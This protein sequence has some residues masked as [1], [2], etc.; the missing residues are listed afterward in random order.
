MY[1]KTI[2]HKTLNI[3]ELTFDETAIQYETNLVI[4]KDSDCK[5]IVLFFQ[6]DFGA[7]GTIP[8]FEDH[9]LNTSYSGFPYVIW[10]EEMTVPEIRVQPPVSL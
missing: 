7:A 5:W 1:E 8:F 2:F 6:G 3:N 10:T 9:R 4:G